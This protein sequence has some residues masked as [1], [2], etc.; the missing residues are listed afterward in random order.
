MYDLHYAGVREASSRC[1]HFM[2]KMVSAQVLSENGN[3]V[4]P[5]CVSP[6][7]MLHLMDQHVLANH[8]M[9][10]SVCLAQAS[11][12]EKEGSTLL[13]KIGGDLAITALP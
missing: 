8:K 12:S 10:E 3:A 6:F 13:G 11:C 4:L 5:S 1:L 2:L 7:N 9:L